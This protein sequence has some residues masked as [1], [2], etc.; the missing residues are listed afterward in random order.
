MEVSPFVSV[1]L[2]EPERLEVVVLQVVPPELGRSY[3]SD[4]S[5]A[6]LGASRSRR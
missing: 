5:A 4:S 1:D 3:E 6:L 2:E